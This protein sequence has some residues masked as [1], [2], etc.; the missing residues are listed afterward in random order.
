MRRSLASIRLGKVAL[1]ALLAV[2]VAAVLAGPAVAKPG[3][4][5]HGH[6]KHGAL[7]ISKSSFGQ[8]ADGT[9]I[10]RYTLANRDMKVSIITRPTTARTACTA[11]SR[12]STSASGPPSRSR[13]RAWSD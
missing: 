4:G 1:A 3:P 9:A 13:A 12:A 10:D 5:K 7:S 11:A 2:L 8:L 6:G